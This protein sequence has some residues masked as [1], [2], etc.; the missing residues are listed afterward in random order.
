[1]WPCHC[2]ELAGQHVSW[3]SVQVS[4]LS[5]R[6]SSLVGAEGL[7]VTAAICVITPSGNYRRSFSFEFSDSPGWVRL[8]VR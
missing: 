4:L 6:K 1:M 5:R 8:R 3:Y 2:E 7:P